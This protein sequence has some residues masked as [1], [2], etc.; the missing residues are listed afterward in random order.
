MKEIEREG[1]VL[2][3]KVGKKGPARVVAVGPSQ[4]ALFRS[5]TKKTGLAAV[6]ET[7]PNSVTTSDG[8]DGGSRAMSDRG[9]LADDDDDDDEEEKSIAL[10]EAMSTCP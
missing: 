7:L 5:H 6:I 1:L 3:K 8:C 2:M 9:G 4:V 10:S